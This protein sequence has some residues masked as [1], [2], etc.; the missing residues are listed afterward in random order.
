MQMTAG[1]TRN[2]AERRRRRRILGE[3]RA[4]P[5]RRDL[6]GGEG[7]MRGGLE[8]EGFRPP[9]VHAQ[10]QSARKLQLAVIMVERTRVCS[11]R[12]LFRKDTGWGGGK[13]TNNNK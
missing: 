4:L 7:N 1:A 6:G 5:R 9:F 10:S 11:Y 8:S 12:T 2:A 3:D 13:K